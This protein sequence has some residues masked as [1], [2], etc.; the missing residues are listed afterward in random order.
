MSER[1]ADLNGFWTVRNN[2]LTKVGV[3]EYSAAQVGDA[4][5]PPDTIVKVFRPPE[6]LS[7]PETI[8]S[9][10]LL[11]LIDD[12]VML[13]DAIGDMPA[14]RKGVHGVIGDD[15]VFNP[16]DGYL[17]STLKIFSEAL[18]SLIDQ[19]KRD[20]SIGYLCKY[21]K[22]AGTFMGEAYDY[23]QTNIRGNHVALVKEGR[24]GDD[25]CVLDSF[26]FSCDQALEFN[27]D[28]KPNTPA[29]AP[30]VG[31]D[32]DP[33][34]TPEATPAAPDGAAIL[35]LIALLPRLKAVL[36]SMPSGDQEQP[37]ATAAAP[38]AV[39]PAESEDECAKPAPAMDAASLT[40]A[41]YAD[42]A[43]RDDLY[44]RL[45]PVIG[46]FD[47]KAMDS[48]AIAKY[49]AEKLG[50]TGGFAE[51]DA[52]LKGREAA[53][54]VTRAQDAATTPAASGELDA[55]LAEGK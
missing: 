48:E 44:G 5:L 27:M 35:E 26:T 6:S 10:R 8:A 34:A 50:I 20:L 1:T 7:D 37:P 22:Q 9:F 46:A 2:P 3:F 11:P 12:H 4:T 14:E 52:F 23:V 39:A 13:G 28:E 29:A 45:S 55:Y 42:V 53:A 25:V 54:T 31:K 19:G 18:K 40:R 16:E 38:A 30:A 15:V 41:V 32:I 51:V 43:K 33:A 21:I 47:H 24:A 17:R 49:G 36:G